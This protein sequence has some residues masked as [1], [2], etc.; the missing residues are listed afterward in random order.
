MQISRK[1]KIIIIIAL[2]I[3]VALI[4]F[5][6]FL[7]FCT[8]RN[9]DNL[10]NQLQIVFFDKNSI[11]VTGKN[12]DL[13]KITVE[14]LEYSQGI[15]Y[16]KGRQVAKIRNEYG[17][18]SFKIFY[19]GKPIAMTWIFKTNWWHTHDY[20]FDI[21]KIDTTFQFTFN[22]IGPNSESLAYKI[23]EIDSLKY[24]LTETF[25]NRKGRN[26]Q[27]YVEYYDESWKLVADEIWR[28]DTLTNLNLYQDGKWVKNYSTNKYSKTAKYKLI[29][30]SSRADSLVYFFKVIEF[31]EVTDE[32][33]CLKQLTK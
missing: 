4:G 10:L 8:F 33:V 18:D 9:Q 27:V 29:K 20:F 13:N 22:V 5:F 26:G 11:T 17:G 12:I 1:R 6:I 7:K 16:A 19:D 25:Y 21:T 2:A 14:C 24:T 15:V 30:E 23:Y 31:E 3:I 28:N 32:R